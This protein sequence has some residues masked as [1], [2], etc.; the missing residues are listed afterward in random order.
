M[1]ELFHFDI[2]LMADA[3][4]ALYLQ[5]L[6][7]SM[8]EEILRYKSLSDQK[9]RLISRL[10]LRL[11]LG[12][13]GH[14]DLLDKVKRNKNNKPYIDSWKSFSI[15]HAG[16][17]VV[18]C[19]ADNGIGIGVDIE[20][21]TELN[22]PEIVQ[23]FHFEEQQYILS[24]KNIQET[25][26]EIWAKKE[27][28]LKAIGTGIVNGLNELSCIHPKIYYEGI[29]W[30]FHE[31]EIHPGYASYLCSSLERND[32]VKSEFSLPLVVNNASF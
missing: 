32:I 18:F 25:F 3:E 22:Y 1:T 27:A 5:M 19:I 20:R 23:Y 4:I 2:N 21:K 11:C 7:Q 16:D 28:F 8:K 31:L 6:P 29:T 14:M 13:S 12:Q 26:Y 10:M 30:H 9:S 24:S 15:S 17:L